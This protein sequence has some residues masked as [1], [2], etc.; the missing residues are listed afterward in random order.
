MRGSVEAPR[1]TLLERIAERPKP[2]D[3]RMQ[4][5][6]TRVL[7]N[8]KMWEENKCMRGKAFDTSKI[9]AKEVVKVILRD[10]KNSE[11]S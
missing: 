1:A 5:S 11:K 3:A 9:S 8:L 6:K 4:I 2:K 7:K 10:I